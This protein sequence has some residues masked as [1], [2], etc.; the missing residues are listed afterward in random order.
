MDLA[1]LANLGEFVGGIAVLVTLIYLGLQ[2]RSNTRAVRA[3][4]FLGSTNGWLDYIY[5][6]S[7]PPV[8]DLL[9]R[10]STHPE[11]LGISE[12]AQMYLATRGQFRRFEN[13]Y[14]QFRNGLFD[15]GTWSGYRNSL[16]ED[17]LSAP[18]VR[19]FWRLHRDKF[20]PEFAA[21]VDREAVAAKDA[22]ARSEYLALDAQQFA[23]LLAEETRSLE[24][25]S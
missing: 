9:T 18:V 16:R 4:T 19:A 24:E 17:F 2:V 3:S 6:A 21:L 5:F 23:D 12:L 11:S 25:P 7:R 15:Q 22:G 1:Q 10:A 14:Y 8:A 20:A 13:D